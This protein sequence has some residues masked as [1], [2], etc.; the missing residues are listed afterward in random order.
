MYKC[1]IANEKEMNEKWDYE[2]DTNED[3]DNW[4]IWKEKA[5]KCFKHGAQ[6][7]YYGILDGKIISEA[8]ASLSPDIVQNGKELVDDKTAYLTAFRTIKEYQ[9]QG[10]FSKLFK[11]MINDL[12]SR[13]YTRVTVGVEPTELTNKAIYKKYGF[14]NFIKT[15]IETYPDGTQI[16]V[17]YYYKDI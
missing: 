5:I 4:I 3:K 8:T 6:I 15:S 1:K 12:K 7:P 11:Y 16:E 14:T 2:I 10:Y 17:E 9:G 13:G